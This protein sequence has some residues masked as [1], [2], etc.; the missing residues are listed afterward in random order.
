MHGPHA[1][2]STVALGDPRPRSVPNPRPIPQPRPPP[3][4]PILQSTAQPH[5]GST[6]DGR[7]GQGAWGRAGLLSL[8]LSRSRSPA[9]LRR[10]CPQHSLPLSRGFPPGAAPG[11]GG[12]QGVWGHREQRW[13]AWGVHGPHAGSSTVALG[14]PRPRS[15]PN[16]RPIPQPR[17]P[18]LIPILQSTA[19]P[20]GGSTGDGRGGQGAWGRAG[21]LSLSLSRS[22]SPAHLRRSCPQHSLPLSRG[23][24]PGAAR[25]APVAAALSCG[26]ARAAGSG[27]SLRRAVPATAGSQRPLPRTA[28][29]PMGAGGAAADQ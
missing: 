14:D 18:P 17:P 6:G 11:S 27:A 5:G 23:F 2:S 28:A 15:V 29:Q 9:H 20:H 1:G 3:L 8:S 21:L 12:L 4:I 19:Q 25:T 13:R 24:P 26:A 16:P 7:G 22:R 10:S